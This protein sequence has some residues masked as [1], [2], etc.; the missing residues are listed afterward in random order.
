MLR[1]RESAGRCDTAFSFGDCFCPEILLEGDD[2][3]IFKLYGKLVRVL[4]KVGCLPSEAVNASLDEFTSFVVEAR[5]RHESS[6]RSAEDIGDIIVHLM[7]DYG[8]LARSNL[9]P[10]FKLCWLVVSRSPLQLPVVDIDR[11]GWGVPAVVVSSAVQSVQSYICLRSFKRSAFF[12]A[13]TMVSVR[14]A[15]SKA[16]EIMSAA[17]FDP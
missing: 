8:L 3:Y 6:G 9:V 13:V 10:V 11:T 15:V 14:D 17:D 12:T 7:S 2:P 16:R 5:T 1:V 4:E